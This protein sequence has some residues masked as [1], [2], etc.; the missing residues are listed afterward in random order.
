M[1]IIVRTLI[2]LVA[3]LIVV[4]AAV[5]FAQSSFAAALAPGM[6]AEERGAAPVLVTN[7]DTTSA[8]GTVSTVT[9]TTP[10]S[11]TAAGAAAAAFTGEGTRGGHDE[12]GGIQG[13]LPLAKNFAI[14]ALI[15]GV[16]ALAS[17]GANRLRR[18]RRYLPAR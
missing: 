16:V 1:K 5:G 2:I 3:A 17:Q 10:D 15:V 7:A 18:Q 8:D 4:A 9:F 11:A 14:M 6:P 13:A 12:A